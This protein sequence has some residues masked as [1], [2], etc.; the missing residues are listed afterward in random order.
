MARRVQTENNQDN[1]NNQFYDVNDLS[2]DVY[3][4][5]QNEEDGSDYDQEIDPE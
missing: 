3:Y 2:D 5:Q 4:I 1:F